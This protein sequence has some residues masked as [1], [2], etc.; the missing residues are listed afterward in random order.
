[1][2]LKKLKKLM[3]ASV[4]KILAFIADR[5]ILR[6]WGRLRPKKLWTYSNEKNFNIQNLKAVLRLKKL[7]RKFRHSLTFFGSRTF[8]IQ[9]KARFETKYDFLTGL[10]SKRPFEAADAWGQ[11]NV[12]K[13]LDWETLLF[14]EKKDFWREIPTAKNQSWRRLQ[15]AKTAALKSVEPPRPP[16]QTIYQF[17]VYL[18]IKMWKVWWL[19]KDF[20]IFHASTQ[21]IQ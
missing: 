19:C 16:R 11:K 2:L 9:A 17:L 12:K 3:P 5:N 7:R 8:T 10:S 13:S 14:N 21:F 20:F 1:M 18:K 15:N 4:A 6:L